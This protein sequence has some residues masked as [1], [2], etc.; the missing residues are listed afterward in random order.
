MSEQVPSDSCPVCAQ[1]CPM[2]ADYVFYCKCWFDPFKDSD[3]WDEETPSD[4]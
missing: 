3:S 2:C 1:I 4:L